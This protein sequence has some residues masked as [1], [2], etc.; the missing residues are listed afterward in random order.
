MTKIKTAR[1][2]SKKDLI[3]KKGAGLFRTKS[4]AAAS[5]RDLA[6][7]VGVEAPSL[8][9]HIGSKGEILQVICFKVAAEFT[10]QLDETEKEHLSAAAKIE[11]LVRFHINMMINNFDEVFVANNDWKYLDEPFLNNF[12]NQRRAYE[13][14]MMAII[15]T[16]IKKK[17]FKNI[18]PYVAVLTLLSAVRGLEFWQKSKRNISAKELEDDMINHLITGLI[19]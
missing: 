17:E 15:E 14:R 7:I 3:I 13:K 5:M 19:K 9:N 1:N 6:D 2:C 8:Y 12:L 18:H 10:T 4:F 16:G 11:A